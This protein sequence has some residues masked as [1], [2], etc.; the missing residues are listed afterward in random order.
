MQ[1]ILLGTSQRSFTCENTVWIQPLAA[2]TKPQGESTLKW[3]KV[4]RL[5]TNPQNQTHRAAF[6]LAELANTLTPSC[7][8]CHRRR[9]PCPRANTKGAQCSPL[10]MRGSQYLG[11]DAEAQ[12]P[13]QKTEWERKIWSISWRRQRKSDWCFGSECVVHQKNILILTFYS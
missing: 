8:S 1:N 9:E 10:V 6:R 2:C 3:Y 5:D 11:E 7:L 13:Y 4:H 12:I